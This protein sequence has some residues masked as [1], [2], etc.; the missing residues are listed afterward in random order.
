MLSDPDIV[1]TIQTRAF[2]KKLTLAKEIIDYFSI[3]GVSVAL[4]DHDL[5][6]YNNLVDHEMHGVLL[7]EEE[8]LTEP[9]VLLR[10]GPPLRREE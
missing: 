7:K 9:S 1:I 6:L 4:E 3:L 8:L 10:L 2:H 5:I